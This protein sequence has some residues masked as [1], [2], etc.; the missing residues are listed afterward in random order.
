M[1]S[2]LVGKLFGWLPGAAVGSLIAG[3]ALAALWDDVS[4]ADQCGFMVDAVTCV[5]WFGGHFHFGT[6]LGIAVAV[7]AVIGAMVNVLIVA[8][9]GSQERPA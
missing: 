4:S 5:S 1:N 2:D 6:A 7:G 8:V 3:V 9:Q